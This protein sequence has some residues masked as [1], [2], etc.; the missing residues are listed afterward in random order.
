MQPVH[1]FI[2]VISLCL[3][4]GWQGLLAYGCQNH[5]V[6]VDPTSVQVRSYPEI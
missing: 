1:T 2:D 4:R 3:F 5:V 6:V